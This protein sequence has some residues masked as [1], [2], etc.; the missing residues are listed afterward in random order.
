[1]YSQQIKVSKLSD[2]CRIFDYLLLH[3]AA[4]YP[5]KNSLKKAFKKQRIELNGKTAQT[6]DWLAENDVILLH[7][8]SDS[9]HKEFPLDLEL[10]YEDAFMAVVVKPA[11]YPVSGN[12]YKTI[13]NALSYNLSG[14]EED[15]ALAIPRPVHRLDKLTSGILLIAK[16]RRAQAHLGLQFEHK[17]LDKTYVALVKGRVEGK[18]RIDEP[19][20]EQAALTHYSSLRYERSLSYDWISAV[21][22]QPETG[23]THQLRIH[24]SSL[25]H[26]IIGDTLYDS[27]NVLKGK[28][29]FLCAQKIVF[30]HPIHSQKM[31][32]EI[33]V[34]KKFD[35]LLNRELRRWEKFKA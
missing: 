32:F 28:G 11:G 9:V 7:R 25:K 13:Q 20:E 30:K 16:T 14:S 35:A 4:V 23:R 15:D 29:L 18:G 24:L 19:I 12:S 22:L 3:A 21:K 26:P 8:A 33:P 5:T 27:K 10:L 1:M 6:G 2:S 34:P 31:A 17:T